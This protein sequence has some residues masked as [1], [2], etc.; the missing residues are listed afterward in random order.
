M[1]RD[2]EQAVMDLSIFKR[3]TVSTESGD[4]GTTVTIK[5][6]EKKFNFI[7]PK[8]N[9]NGDGDITY[10]VVWRSDNLF[11]LNQQSKVTLAKTDFKDTDEDEE[12]EVAWKF[13]Y[14]R[15]VGTPY[16]M[17]FDVSYEQTNL[18]E[19]IDDLTGSYERDLMRF[20]LLGGRWMQ[21]Q[22]PSR[23]LQLRSGVLWEDYQHTY[24][25]GT[26]GL[27]PDVTVQALVGE[28]EGYYVHD[29]LFSRSGSHYLYSLTL[30][31][32]LFGSEVN[33][34]KH[35]FFY[36]RYI[37]MPGLEHTNLNLQL[38]GGRTNRSVLGTPEFRIGGSRLL[39]GY[40]RDNVEGNVYGVLNVE[41]L[42]PMFNRRELRGALTFDAGNAW[43]DS[44]DFE[45]TDL[46]YSAGVGLRWKLKSFV[47]VD[48]RLDISHGLSDDGETKAYLGTNATF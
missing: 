18:D 20:R 15:I 1:L 21:Q 10:G 26:D 6:A 4:D 13:N 9:R 2:A 28:A 36:R 19:T 16:S 30:A 27:L 8:L 33:F 40:D 3:V 37:R 38:R 41:Y 24:V 32:D 48:I 35:L 17:G 44:D 22:G 43:E 46:R 23:G 47:K 34:V 5:V 29:H 31:D 11:G 25:S 14:P 42:R 7:L 45:L 12:R 39:R